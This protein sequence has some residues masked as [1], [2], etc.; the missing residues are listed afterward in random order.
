MFT[1]AQIKYLPI[2][3]HDIAYKISGTGEKFAI[4]LQGWGTSL[5]LYDGIANLLVDNYKILQFDFPGF[6]KSEE[7]NVG[8]SVSENADIFLKICSALGIKSATLIGHS[9]GGRVIIEVASKKTD[10]NVEKI[11]LIDSAGVMPKRSA[12][13][14]FKSKIFKGKRYFLTK[15]FIYPLFSVVIDDWLSRQGSADYRQASPVMKQCLVKA[16]NYD[17]TDIMH[18]IEAET[19]LIWGENDDATPLEDGRIMERE[20]RQARLVKVSDAGH[21]SF[22]EA[23]QLVGAEIVKFLGCDE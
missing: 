10:L 11:V 3:G 7:P 19:L 23:P 2:D 5:D 12:F 4:I 1:R 20:F 14:K 13:A 15:T 6:G 9:Y 16:V 8:F 18:N 17:Q 22:I 21:F